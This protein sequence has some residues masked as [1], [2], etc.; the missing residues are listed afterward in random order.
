MSKLSKL[1]S[2]PPTRAERTMTAKD[3]ILCVRR[4][5]RGAFIVV[6]AL[7]LAGCMSSMDRPPRALTPIP[8]NQNGFGIAS[9]SA[10]IAELSS[11]TPEGQYLPS[12]TDELWVI[13][14]S[15]SNSG[16]PANEAS[17]QPGSGA[18]VVES[19]G[20]GKIVPLPLRH[21]DVKA[22]VSA[23]I[24]TVEV[25]Q[26]FT[27]PF[28]GKIE[29]KYVFPL[30]QDAAVNE[31]AMTIGDRRIRGIIRE[32]EEAEKIYAEA[33]QQGYVASL[34]TQERPNIF[35]QSVAN[36]EPGKSIDV[37]ITY[38]NTL[39]YRDGW[40]E[41]VFPMVVGP[42]FNPPG[43]DGGVEAVARQKGAAGAPPADSPGNDS[44]TAGKLPAANSSTTT[45]SYLAPSERSGHD[46]SLSLNIDAGIAI[47]EFE[48]KSHVIESKQ[49]SPNQLH[50]ELGQLD[51]IPN[52]DFVLRYRVAGD[53]LK[54]DFL[55]HHDE[56]GGFFTLMVYPPTDLN[57]LRQHPLE[58]VFVLDC[59]G[60]MAGEP[61]AQAKS[62]IRRAVQKMR[63]EDSFQI[64]SFSND[65]SKLG[66]RPLAA[67]PENVQRGLAY[68]DSL[69]GQGG[70]MMVEGIKA[71][72]DFP[73]DP[74]R[75]RFVVFLTDGYIGNESQIFSAVQQ[76]LGGSR[77][78]SFGV[79]SSVNG[80]LLDGL[81]RL[82]RG[83]VAY[84]GLKDD[85]AQI[86]DDFMQRVR[87]PALTDVSIDWGTFEVKD[88]Y[89]SR[90]PDVFVGRPLV[91]TGRF[92]VQQKTVLKVH[93][94]AGNEPVAIAIAVDPN[95]ADNQHAGI[96]SVWARKKIME[97][98]D[99]QS[100][101]ED[102][103]LPT[104]IKQVALDFNL[105]SAYTAF[106]AVDSL[107]QTGDSPSTAV[108]QA[109][110]VPEGVK[111]ENTVS[112]TGGA[113]RKK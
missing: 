4:F 37:S 89:P 69:N 72:L 106:V 3:F 24:A 21:T 25:R 53:R 57:Q 50:V 61:I 8:G 104:Q 108:Q 35:T 112:P 2:E 109:V 7:I 48:S 29:A 66:K 68:L 91:M 110:P 99:K 75:L 34:L 55:T 101:V 54:S 20:A 88:V 59:S 1:K 45:V 64:I 52:K 28:S 46:I 87:H 96:A 33:K 63:P 49:P 41:F 90:L 78:F 13:A 80:Y 51:R 62:A 11:G 77:I 19:E 47:E 43:F 60:S 84:L 10:M 12:S 26:T 105:M 65:A 5:W 67:T 107:S 71:A 58:M 18:M 98:S 31:F 6:V 73:H 100:A 36:I 40:Y 56:R 14:R 93:G 44:K 23:Y 111:Y 103:T 32:R 15:V 70:T 9:P 74:E 113:D 22:Q 82:G 85:A 102:P 79:G 92:E 39:P 83:A 86:M 42:R 76:R 17:D 95:L 30:P 38:F 97:F 81:A 16:P 94:R 27:N